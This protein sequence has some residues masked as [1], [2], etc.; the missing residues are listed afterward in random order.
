MQEE[1]RATLEGLRPG[2]ALW[3]LPKFAGHSATRTRIND[4]A[5]SG[6]GEPTTFRNFFEVVRAATEIRE[7]TG[8]AAAKTVIIT[9]ATGFDRPNVKE[10]FAY[11]DVHNGEIW[12]KLDA[13]TPEYFKTIDRTDFP[14]EKILANICACAQAREIIIQSC[15]MYLRGMGPT[16]AE[17]NAY[18]ERLNAFARQGARIKLI[19][20]Y[21][22]ARDP[23]FGIVSSLPNAMVDSLVQRVRQ[24]TPYKA[25]GFYGTVPEGRGTLGE[26]PLP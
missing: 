3:Q 21:T 10:A 24:E 17:F 7:Q 2:G 6:D 15:F 18:L 20:I 13:G 22:V 9:N 8:F 1:L 12:A 19:Q 4:I 14:F 25:A 26:T 11:L 23:A 5:F 16:A